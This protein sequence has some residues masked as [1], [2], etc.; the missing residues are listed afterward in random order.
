MNSQYK[1]CIGLAALFFSCSKPGMLD[2]VLS[3]GEIVYPGKAD[4]VIINGGKSRMELIWATSDSRITHFKVFWNNG[5][6]SAEVKAAHNHDQLSDTTRLLLE[7]MPEARYLFKVI[8]F[9]AS[10]NR[11]VGAEGEGATYGSMYRNALLNRGLRR[12]VVA[13]DGNAEL[14]WMPADSLESVTT[15]HYT[16]NA[17]ASQTI[18]IQPTEIQTSLADYKRGTS[19]TYSTAYRP[20]K[21]GLDTFYA[22]A[23][24]AV[25]LVP[26]DKANFSPLMLPGDAGTAWGWVL[27]YLWDGSI[28]EGRGYHTPD[29]NL[30]Q[31]FNFDLGVTAEL[32]EIK[33]WQRQG[34]ANIFNGGN[35]K[36]FEVWGS[37]NPAADGSYS[38]WTLIQDCRGVKPSG[39]AVGTITQQDTDYAAAGELYKFP[40]A[41]PAYRYIR[42][43]ILERWS[44]TSRNI[45]MMEVSFWAKPF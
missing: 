22:K 9:D 21:R 2:E 26:L 40:E 37:N 8:S 11:S 15:L 28:A 23:D 18:Q 6:D 14:D 38:G 27:P 31:H 43:K 30:P 10:G 34:A 16:D 32:R 36:R 1:W 45:H 20:E 33:W 4:T 3:K 17:G 7:N 35:P 29:L 42:I 24:N 25:S 12:A 19:F 5:A 39:A 13:P 44:T 41:T